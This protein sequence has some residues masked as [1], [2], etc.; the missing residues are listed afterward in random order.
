MR[1]SLLTIP[2]PV[3]IVAPFWSFLKFSKLMYLTRRHKKRQLKFYTSCL[4]FIPFLLST[5]PAVLVTF[6]WS[7]SN[8]RILL[9]MNQWYP[10][11]YEMHVHF[12]HDNERFVF[13]FSTNRIWIDTLFFVSICDLQ[14][15]E[16]H[17]RTLSASFWARCSVENI[18]C[19]I[20]NKAEIVDFKTDG[21]SWRHGIKLRK[22]FIDLL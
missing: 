15:F 11:L 1:I 19:S 18:T 9:G 3:Y 20:L 5:S 21:F 6:L 8:W 22:I 10:I 16:D 2:G 13:S 12:A 17:L 7:N 14:P 4:Q